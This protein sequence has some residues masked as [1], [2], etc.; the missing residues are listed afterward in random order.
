MNNV[1]GIQ[2]SDAINNTDATTQ[3]Q[4]LSLADRITM[5]QLEA[6]SAEEAEVRKMAGKVQ[7]NTNNLKQLSE[8]EAKLKAFNYPDA[9]QKANG[10]HSW[11]VTGNSFPKSIHLDGG[12]KITV[13]DNDN[14][15]DIADANGN[16]TTIWGD[17]HVSEN[18]REG[19]W[20]FHDDSTFV[21]PDGTKISVGTAP[22]NENT[23]ITVTESLTITK[24]HQSISVSGIANNQPTVGQPSFNGIALDDNTNDGH[25]FQTGDNVADWVYNGKEVKGVAKIV[26]DKIN[27]IGRNQQPPPKNILE[28]VLTP[29]DLSL[30]KELGVTIYDSSGIGHL[31]ESEIQNAL[32]QLSS[33]KES[34]KSISNLDMVKLQAQTNKMQ[35]HYSIAS[36]TMKTL[37]NAARE[38]IRNT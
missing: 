26:S 15:W 33:A 17:P 4:K 5:T 9:A 34:L 36:Q 6:A 35:Q 27:E 20:D 13:H 38:I 11:S 31:T 2:S 1:N 21:L 10:D 30:L 18:D 12:Y 7:E 29:D 19:Y 8:I 22:Y 28:T 37:F 3:A 25:I 16:V 24:G 32:G 23:D 14:K